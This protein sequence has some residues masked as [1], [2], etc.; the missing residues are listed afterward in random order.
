MDNKNALSII[1]SAKKGGALAFVGQG[2]SETVP[3]Y[4]LEPTQI[5]V[6]RENFHDLQGKLV[7][8]KEVCDR[9][10]DAAG[11]S[12]IDAHVESINAP[13]EP[14]LDL[15]ARTIFIGHA[16]GK[17]RLPDGSWRESAPE[18]YEFDYVAKA[19][20]EA[21]VDQAK[22]KKKMMEYYKAGPMRAA[23]GARLRVI[24][25]LTGMPTA[26]EAGEIGQSKT[27]VFSRIVQNT[28]YILSTPE[29]KMMAIAMATGAAAQLYGNKPEAKAPAPAPQGDPAES[30]RPAEGQRTSAAGSEFPDDD[31]ELEGGA[32]PAVTPEL[33]K[34]LVTLNE[35]AN[36]SDERVAKRARAILDKGVTDIKT[37]TLALEIIKYMGSGASKGLKTCAEALDAPVLDAIVLE[38]VCKMIRAAATA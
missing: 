38:P 17:T 22:A 24:R 6:K 34:I 19:T 30:A 9:V 28:D 36:A 26:F 7:M 37:L 23:T 15:P 14:A 5:E 10:A 35:W 32:G 21:G 18:T 27:F 20:A 8:K 29:G 2:I 11:I 25:Q 33:E 31:F 3:L 12:F 1:E 16:Q 4:K 13:A